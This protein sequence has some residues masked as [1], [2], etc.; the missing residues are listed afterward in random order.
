MTNSFKLSFN[1]IGLCARLSSHNKSYPKRILYIDLFGMMRRT[2]PII[3][4]RQYCEYTID[5]IK[6]M[7]AALNHFDGHTKHRASWNEERTVETMCV[8]SL[9]DELELEVN[10]FFCSLNR[11]FPSSSHISVVIRSTG[12]MCGTARK[13]ECV[14]T[15]LLAPQINVNLFYE[16][17]L[18]IFFCFGIFMWHFW[19]QTWIYLLLPFS[20]VGPRN[21]RNDSRFVQCH[22]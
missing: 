14:E 7:M 11:H 2:A 5:C 13:F 17:G 12:S 22:V 15:F 8:R 4:S 21:C 9:S 16:L 20:F 3:F 19:V 6:L 1:C 10:T 18:F